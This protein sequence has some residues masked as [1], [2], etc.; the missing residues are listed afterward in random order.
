M[1]KR[2]TKTLMLYYEGKAKLTSKEDNKNVVDIQIFD[3]KIDDDHQ[4]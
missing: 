4:K 2:Y 1:N 3:G